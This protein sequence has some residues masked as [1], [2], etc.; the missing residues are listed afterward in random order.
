[1]D[2]PL[3][4][5]AATEAASSGVTFS[6][7]LN[8]IWCVFLVLVGVNLLIIVHE[9]GH[10]IVARMCGVRCDK[11]YIW[12]D[13]YGWK[14]FKFKWGDT[15]YGL[16]VLPLG[17][18]VKML[19]QE[20]NPG[21]IKAEIERAKA[22]QNGETSEQTDGQSNGE[23]SNG[24]Q[25]AKAEGEQQAPSPYTPEQL[26]EMLYAKDSYLSKSV[27]QRLAIIT[28]GVIM[29][30]VLAFVCA[31]IA[32]SYGAESVP[33]V[34]G[35]TFTGSAAWQGGLQPGD[36]I[37][38][39]D[40]KNI[41]TFQ[42]ITESIVRATSKE[43]LFLVQRPGVETPV[44]LMIAPSM[45]GKALV[46]TTGSQALG[47]LVVGGLSAPNYMEKTEDMKKIKAGDRLLAVNG[48][49]LASYDE[50]LDLR[51]RLRGEPLTYT[52]EKKGGSETYEATL[53]PVKQHTVGLSFTAGPI[54]AM[55][56]QGN[57]L[58]FQKDDQILRVDDVPVDPLKFASMIYDK[59]QAGGGATSFLVL[60]GNEQLTL[61]INIP[62]HGKEYNMMTG[63]FNPNG[64]SDILGI[65]FQILPTVSAS[66]DE[67]L[68]GSELKKFAIVG[69]IPKS[70]QKSGLGKKIDDGYEV[71]YEQ[72][73]NS[74]FNFYDLMYMTL[75][76]F[77]T[78]TQ[79]RITATQA[80]GKVIESTLPITA[81]DDWTIPGRYLEFPSLTETIKAE[82]F[83]DAVSKGSRKAV[84]D[85]TLVYH[86]VRNL[87]MNFTGD[88]R[89]SPKGLGGP[90]TIV[91]MAYNFADMGLGQYLLFLCLLSANLAVLNILPIPV[92]D[93]GHVVF[94]LYEAIFRKP[95][96]ET[97]QIILSYI[98]LLLLLALM[99]W[100]FALDLGF[101]KRF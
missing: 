41:S 98:G 96:N 51:N 46:A 13:I 90:I 57:Q 82:N 68:V 89:V 9:F 65:A 72:F 62:A 32:Y 22:A 84:R 27:P 73:E 99:V 55:L 75:Q 7:V 91:K 36:R 21:A 63:G 60:R 35:K 24:E 101:I 37:L 15:E 67:K 56:E 28:A 76:M 16:G 47:E 2:F 61:E 85:L 86:F 54:F 48:R 93:G 29:N 58:G 40:G 44:E 34:I 81:S 42:E 79:V 92:L 74:M 3:I 25:P 80:D 100:V 31:I 10:F 70:L 88:A 5:A 69:E 45:G 23:N 30:A 83:A 64:G 6:T 77:P 78:E 53:P 39:V 94:L 19:G 97:V 71:S 26:E 14:I 17:G 20:D 66:D 1:M 11:F 49:T 38:S 50:Y 4:W 18:Y 59:S 43:S 52:F 12:F 8:V 33:P 87:L 95:P